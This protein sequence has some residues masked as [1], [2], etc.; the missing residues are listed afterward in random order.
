MICIW[1]RWQFTL[2]NRLRNSSW[3]RRRRV[4]W[5]V[6]LSGPCKHRSCSVTCVAWSVLLWWA[7][8]HPQNISS[9]GM[10]C[11]CCDWR[12]RVVFNVMDL[13]LVCSS[14]APLASAGWLHFSWKSLAMSLT[15]LLGYN[16]LWE[17]ACCFTANEVKHRKKSLSLA[18]ETSNFLGIAVNAAISSIWESIITSTFTEKWR[19]R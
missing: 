12:V 19:K 8:G 14:L 7:R 1:D 4:I 13:E 10:L 3:K 5:Y 16:N 2:W 6:T 17:L 18:E 11:S 9:C 15:F